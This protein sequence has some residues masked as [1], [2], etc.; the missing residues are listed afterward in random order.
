[1][2]LL[3]LYAVMWPIDDQFIRS[4][5]IAEQLTVNNFLSHILL[6]NNIGLRYMM[7]PRLILGI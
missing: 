7:T 5:L 4:S 3:F 2:S 1:M 6:S